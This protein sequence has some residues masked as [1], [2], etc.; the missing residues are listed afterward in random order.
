MHAGLYQDSS[1]T[2]LRR[3][4]R[5]D[6]TWLFVEPSQLSRRQRRSMA[7]TTSGSGC[8]ALRETNDIPSGRWLTGAARMSTGSGRA[9][10]LAGCSG[11]AASRQLRWSAI[12]QIAAADHYP[13]RGHSLPPALPRHVR[14]RSS[15]ATAQAD[16]PRSSSD[17]PD[18]MADD[19]RRRHGPGTGAMISRYDPSPRREERVVSKPAS[20]L[21]TEPALH[22]AR[23]RYSRSPGARSGAAYT[24]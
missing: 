2:P 21:T 23:R 19:R 16:Q 4:E 20:V 6:E 5:R 9:R 13:A 8:S 1:T 24:R 15:S 22:Q 17:H 18:Q 10:A 7:S 3:I 14:S 12:R 11:L